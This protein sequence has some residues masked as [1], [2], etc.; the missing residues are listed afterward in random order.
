MPA[1]YLNNPEICDGVDISAAHNWNCALRLVRKAHRGYT[2]TGLRTTACLR[3]VRACFDG[4]QEEF[5]CMVLRARTPASHVV[6]NEIE[7]I[8]NPR[9]LQRYRFIATLLII[10]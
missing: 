3:E 1:R 8:Q 4:A 10:C 5:D 2:P 9:C 7:N 6:C